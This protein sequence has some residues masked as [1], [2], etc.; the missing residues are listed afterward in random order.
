M[1]SPVL[2]TPEEVRVL[3]CLVEKELTTPENY[4][5]TMNALLAAC[6]QKTSR[7]PVV[8]YSQDTIQ[9]AIQGLKERGFARVVSGAEHRVPKYKH[10]LPFMFRLNPPQTAVLTV[11]MLRGPQTVG[12]IRGRTDR[13]HEFAS[14]DEVADTIRELSDHV[15][16]R[17][18]TELER[19]PGTK[20]PRF[21][22]LL[23]GADAIPQSES[24]RS[25]SDGATASTIRAEV[26]ALRAELAELREE[27]RNFRKQFEG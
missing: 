23:C 22:H 5:L 19:L 24:P 20:E 12:E 10:D 21:A 17:L 9:L 25:P 8:N 1:E 11:L 15:G 7:D 27:F 2:F 26:E 6:N 14:L 13:M 3:A 18:V 4:P 16:R